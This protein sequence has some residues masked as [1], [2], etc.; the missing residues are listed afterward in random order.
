[1][2]SV[3]TTLML[4]LAIGAALPSSAQELSPDAIALRDR[5]TAR[6]DVVPLTNGIAL[7][8]RTPRG[9]VRLI[10]VSDT[11]AING[12]VVSG[13]E[14]RER[15]GTDADAVLRLSYLA[16]EVR[17]ALFA[18]PAPAAPP[19]AEA[20]A[21]PESPAAPASPP[22]P[23]AP[24][25]PVHRSGGDRV[26]I[27][28]DVNVREDEEVRG[29]VVAVLGSVRIDGRVGDQVVA[30][31][32]SVTLGEHAVVGGDVVSVG[33]HVRRAPGAEIRGAV[34]EVSLSDANVSAHAAPFLG[35]LG[36]LSLF[37]G[38][39]ALPRL[40]GTVFRVVLLLLLA[41][42]A[43]LAARASV[44]GSA[45]RIADNPV[46]ATIVGIAAEILFIPLLVLTCIVLAITIVGIPLLILVP[47]VV[48][49]ML[50]LA[51]VGFSGAA[52]AVGQWARRRFSIGPMSNFGDLWVGLLIILLPLLV[53]R[54]L[55]LGGFVTGPF[56]WLFV[57]AGICVEFL[58][59]AMG[60]GAV[61]TNTFSHW[62]AR[63]R[64]SHPAA[65]PPVAPPA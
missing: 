41:S 23:P 20:P 19:A 16:P 33:G 49:L 37:D 4:A 48:L 34:T 52:L 61:L 58:A 44:E 30:V 7:R 18:P 8:P 50:I 6:F 2:R 51:L 28:G 32:G 65:P 13:A 40:M 63:R 24:P 43:L 36:V 57:L 56:A 64:F 9:D 10:E 54:L 60:L 39:G 27:F 38:F 26:R 17:Q 15:L 42:L 46:K 1:M 25:A 21:A 3:L 5:I 55:A 59:W 35:G 29:Q 53:G 45:Q 31:L 12:D 62:Q 22:A 14:L 47:F 11:I